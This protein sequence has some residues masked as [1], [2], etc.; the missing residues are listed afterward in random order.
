MR[1]FGLIAVALAG[2]AGCSTLETP[3]AVSV[4]AS[5]SVPVSASP[6]P[7]P[8]PARP[9]AKPLT[10]LALAAQL[11]P[12]GLAERSGWASDIHDTLLMLRIE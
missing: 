4:P 10:G 11:L 5:A 8:K 2:L 1:L 6:S 12:P 3:S 7:S 9:A